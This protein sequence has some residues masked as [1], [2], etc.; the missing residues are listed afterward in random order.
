MA[1]P[2]LWIL[3]LKTNSSFVVFDMKLVQNIYVMHLQKPE[4]I[5]LHYKFLNLE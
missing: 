3:D 5:F 4:A 2:T 1:S